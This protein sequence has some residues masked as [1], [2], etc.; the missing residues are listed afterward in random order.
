MNGQQLLCIQEAV[1]VNSAPSSVHLQLLEQ[2]MIV[3]TWT[4]VRPCGLGLF[5]FLF[6]PS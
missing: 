3:H 5:F 6:C 2:L 4:Q 1:P